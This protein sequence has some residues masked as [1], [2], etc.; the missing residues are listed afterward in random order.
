MKGHFGNY[1]GQFVPETLMYP[2]EELEQAY[3]AA[4]RDPEFHAE[5]DR[6]FRNYVPGGAIHCGPG[7]TR[8]K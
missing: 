5:L 1:G 3:E 4:Q 7:L 6:L 8:G 2:L